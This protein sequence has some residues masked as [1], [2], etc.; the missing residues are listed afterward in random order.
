MAKKQDGTKRQSC[1]TSISRLPKRRRIYSME[2]NWAPN[3]FFG[4]FSGG[5]G[6]FFRRHVLS[7]GAYFFASKVSLSFNVFGQFHEALGRV[8]IPSTL[9]NLLAIRKILNRLIKDLERDIDL[10][11]L[12]T[13]RR[14][15][16]VAS[17]DII[18]NLKDIYNRHDIVTQTEMSQSVERLTQVGL[19]EYE[20]KDSAKT[21][22]YFTLLYNTTRSGLIEL[23]Q[24]AKHLAT[25]IRAERDV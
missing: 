21:Q 25:L 16:H 4:T 13:I 23:S 19:I 17:H 3:P 12:E 1:I 6:P 11:V 9:D 7:C 14:N 10:I 5:I 24:S 8:E 22:P 2:L 20:A 18:S 15:D